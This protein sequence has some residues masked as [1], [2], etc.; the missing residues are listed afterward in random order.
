MREIFTRALLLAKRRQSNENE[1]SLSA[2]C[3][4]FSIKETV[5]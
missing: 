1:N 2:V 3:C 5:K 4:S